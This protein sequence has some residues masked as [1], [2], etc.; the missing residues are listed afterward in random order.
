[1]HLPLMVG[2][3]KRKGTAGKLAGEGGLRAQSQGGEA[4]RESRHCCSDNL[5][6]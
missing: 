6:P 1:M 5:Q 3:G 2:E 4:S